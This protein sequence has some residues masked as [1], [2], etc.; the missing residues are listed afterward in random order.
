MDVPLSDVHPTSW[1]PKF[2][3]AHH[4]STR[5]ETLTDDEYGRLLNAG[6]S[7]SILSLYQGMAS[8]ADS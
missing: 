2:Y 6:V 4:D 1:K 7:D 8:T 3:I 5:H